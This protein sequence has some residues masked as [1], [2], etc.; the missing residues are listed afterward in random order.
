MLAWVGHRVWRV[1]Q[2]RFTAGAVGVIFNESG[3]LLLLKH[4]Y[5]SHYTWGLPGGY[6]SRNEDPAV[7]VARELLEE[8]GLVVV[9]EVPL[10]VA[11]SSM[12]GHLDLAYLCRLVSA[13]DM[14][15]SSEILDYGWFA[16][17][18]VPEMLA[19]HRQAIRRACQVR[20]D[21]AW[22]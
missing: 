13:A 17:D 22:V 1:F 2:A 9:A 4:V 21:V 8:T 18:D 12:P 6:V 5:R 20:E 19:F 7:T 3:H 16:L 14:R 11:R 15:L 10:L